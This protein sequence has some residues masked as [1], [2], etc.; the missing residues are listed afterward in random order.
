MDVHSRDPSLPMA[1][2]PKDRQA[3]PWFPIISGNTRRRPHRITRKPRN[4][5]GL[6]GFAFS[7]VPGIVEGSQTPAPAQPS[8]QRPRQDELTGAIV[9]EVKPEPGAHE[10]TIV[11][12]KP[13]ANLS[14]RELCRRGAP[15]RATA[16]PSAF[17]PGRRLPPIG[18]RHSGFRHD[19][20]AARQ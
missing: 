20:A 14:A 17:A 12:H 3:A 18:A 2:D 16:P 15:M 4:R 19:R 10:R 13:T 11:R 6:R 5:P 8:L 7:P 1:A 9:S